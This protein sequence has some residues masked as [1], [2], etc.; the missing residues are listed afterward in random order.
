MIVLEVQKFLRK[1][2]DVS[3]RSLLTLLEHEYGITSTW[4]EQDLLVILNYSQINSPKTERIVQECRGLTLEL[5]S[6]NVVARAFPRFFN[7]G[8][9]LEQTQNFDW[10]N[11]SCTSKED[12]SLILLYN[13]KNSWRVNTRGSFGNGE[14]NSSGY[15][16]NQLFWQTG[17]SKGVIEEYLNP[18]YT[19]VFELATPYNRIVT[20]YNGNNLFLL[21]AF[22]NAI[23]NEIS[24]DYADSLARDLLVSRPNTYKFKSIEEIQKFIEGKPETFEGVVVCDVNGY[25]LKI[26][27]SR[28]LA[29]HRMHGNGNICLAKNLV[30]LAL[31]NEGSEWLAYFPDAKPF[32]EKVKDALEKEVANLLTIWQEACK[33]ESQKDFAQYIVPRT[34][35]SSILFQARKTGQK[36]EDVYRNNGDLLIKTLFKQENVNV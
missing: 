17:I 27:N 23:G 19:Y 10:T 8:E 28:Y 33:L 12:G 7:L 21:T 2:D 36:V 3:A 35:L 22:H 11:F 13:Y 29:L 15:T 24:S 26:K 9:N 20:P 32:Y 16:W 14:V 6:W 5:L 18:E 25:R 4:H 31:S 34:K 1:N 30:P